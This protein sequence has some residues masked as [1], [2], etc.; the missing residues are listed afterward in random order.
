MDELSKFLTE[1]GSVLDIRWDSGAKTY[2]VNITNIQEGKSSCG[3]GAEIGVAV[4]RTMDVYRKYPEHIEH[5]TYMG[6]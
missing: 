5:R 1:T 6:G 4:K 2:K 3:S